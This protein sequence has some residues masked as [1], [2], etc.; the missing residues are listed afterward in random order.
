MAI[1][2]SHAAF[3][4]CSPMARGGSTNEGWTSVMNESNTAAMT[5]QSDQ[6]GKRRSRWWWILDVCLLMLPPY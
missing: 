3:M 1:T 6:S 5:E 2:A 4:S